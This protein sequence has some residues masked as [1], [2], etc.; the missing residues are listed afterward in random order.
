MK[1]HLESFTHK[2]MYQST[3]EC[4]ICGK[5]FDTEDHLELHLKQS[6]FRGEKL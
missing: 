1:E 3:F 4:K 6:H 5:K 2:A